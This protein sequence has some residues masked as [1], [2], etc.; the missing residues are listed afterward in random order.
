MG[1]DMHLY[2]EQ[3]ELYGGTRRLR[4]VEE[5]GGGETIILG[6]NAKLYE[7]MGYWRKA[8]QIHGWFVDN[9]QG[10]EDDCGEYEVTR[11]QLQELL[12]LVLEVISHSKLVP[13]KV[14]VGQTLQNGEWVDV[15]EDGKVIEDPTAAKRHLPT[16]TGFFFGS[17]AYDQHY[18]ADLATTQAILERAL[19]LDEDTLFFYCSSW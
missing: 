5:G 15:L 13:G 4:I 7:E 2:R 10:G 17:T 16:R 1:L 12:Y 11:S 19:S 14:S 3:H 6:S 8:N 9:V 18:L